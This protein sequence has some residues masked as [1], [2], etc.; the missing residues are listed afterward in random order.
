[1]RIF[2][3]LAFVV[4]MRKFRL[5]QDVLHE[6]I[7]R[8]EKRIN[9]I[10]EERKADVIEQRENEKRL[11]EMY[12]DRLRV[13]HESHLIDLKQTAEV[14]KIKMSHL[15]VVESSLR[16]SKPKLLTSEEMTAREISISAQDKR[17]KGTC[18]T[19]DQ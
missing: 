3:C 19:R 18:F 16:D 13:M 4:C 15:E 12:E 7:D 1:M 5:Q 6:K 9:E 10:E 17:L 14:Q 2:L 8:Y 11:K